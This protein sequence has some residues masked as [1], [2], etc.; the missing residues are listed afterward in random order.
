MQ[1]DQGEVSVSGA[2]AASM[3]DMERMR[4]LQSGAWENATRLRHYSDALASGF[5]RHEVRRERERENGSELG[6]GDP[7]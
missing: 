1:H 7:C 2:H 3:R 5:E 4:A 6:R